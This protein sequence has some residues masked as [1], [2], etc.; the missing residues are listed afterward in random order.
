VN[1]KKAKKGKHQ[2][3]TPPA[4]N[5]PSSNSKAFSGSQPPN[6][7]LAPNPSF[8]ATINMLS[9]WHIGSGAGRT[10]D[11]DRLVQRDKDDLPYIPAKT[12]TGI[13]R[14]ACELVAL[15]LD[16]G[17][18]EDGH[19]RPSWQKWIV[20]LFGDQPAEP[21][22]PQKLVE[23]FPREAAL[24]IRSAHLPESLIKA[25]NDKSNLKEAIT[26]IK[27]GIAIDPDSGC[28]KEDY[29]RFE[30]M[31]RGGTELQAH[32]ELNLLSE[33]N[34]QKAAYALLLAGAKLIER[35]GGKRR[36]G[37]GQCKV[38]VENDIT[39][40]IDWIEANQIPPPIPPIPEENTI[41]IAGQPTTE[42]GWVK[43]KLKITAQSP[44]VIRTRTVGNV[45][46]T[47]DYIPGTYL[48]KLIRQQLGDLGAEFNRAVAYGDAVVTNATVAIDE[49][50][51][52][53]V[54]L[55]L[56]SEKLGGGL[57]KGKV[58]NR[59]REPESANQLKGERVG[60]IGSLNEF[61]PEFKK[62]NLTVETHNI[63]EDDRQCPTKDVGGIY[64][65]Q[66]IEAG[67]VLQAELRLR[68][69]LA[70]A[71]NKQNSSWTELQGDYRIG[72]SKKDD[73]GAVA[74]EILEKPSSVPQTCKI[75]G[76]ELV[77]WLLSDVLLRDGR[78]RPTTSI[79]DFAKQLGDMLGVT[80]TEKP[81][82]E[83]TLSLVVRQNRI[84]S[85]QVRWGLP[86]PSLVGLKAGSCIV[87]T[88]DQLPNSQKLAQVQASGIGERR[89]E[90]YGQLCF[91]DPVL[92]SDTS[93][94]TVK[95]KANQSNVESN[96]SS[97]IPKGDRSFDYAR[98]IEKAAWREAIRRAALQ[99][100]SNKASRKADLGID[101][102][103]QTNSQL[104]SLRSIIATLKVDRNNGKIIYHNEQVIRWLDNLAAKDKWTQQSRAKIYELVNVPDRVWNILQL[105][106]SKLVLTQNGEQDL[107]QELWS[108]AVQT[109]V[110]ACIHAHTRE[111]ES[112]PERT[113]V[114]GEVEHGA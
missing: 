33:S 36:R 59:L 65:Y 56:F 54:P 100:A 3:N 84:D 79:K 80:L 112:R 51:G 5:T 110:D 108:E 46:E 58:Y 95:D 71:L 90:G 39:S 20:Y 91:N 15:G 82:Q 18:L 113:L 47:L 73:Y 67:T 1:K 25:L 106:F 52:R 21:N 64:S 19:D 29:L 34:Q 32:C 17:Q 94:L 2:S 103:V 102:Q 43:L 88:V 74:V 44:I 7:A 77:V 63:V 13:W 30:E 92:T 104:G 66:A 70:N 89:A 61:L 98:I 28:A 11:V 75:E 69:G 4:K 53:S 72:Q 6:E 76:S 99:V 37:A 35:L 85:W 101:V 22:R 27:P 60:Y 45:V 23:R 83:D 12:L 42:D 48:L 93:K 24:S 40:W 38:T 10:G 86:R 50:P 68:Q 57:D 31:V 62:V 26:F 111:N 87:F 114:A 49:A 8:T 14:D 109:L 96:H 9:D 41:S 16:D 81:V 78:L 105:S 107:K 97:L 55:A